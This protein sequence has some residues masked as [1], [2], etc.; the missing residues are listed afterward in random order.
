MTAGWGLQHQ[1]ST[2]QHEALRQ[3]ALCTHSRLSSMLVTHALITAR[4][5]GHHH[6]R[7]RMQ[8]T[9]LSGFLAQYSS[10]AANLRMMR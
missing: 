5:T 3:H 4:S 8:G 7:M 9:P 10:S 6:M 1:T 2:R